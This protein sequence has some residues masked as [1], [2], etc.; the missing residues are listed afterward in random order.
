MPNKQTE[1]KQKSVFDN[2]TRKYSLSKTL[3]FELKP[4]GNTPKLL[5]DENVFEKD[6]IIKE[7]YKQTKPYFDYLHR[8][9]IEESLKGQTLSG[10][11]KYFKSLKK[12]QKNKKD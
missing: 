4:I 8:E 3:R 6:R 7:K 10:L 9:F 1:P 2:F 12:L 11:D 5:K